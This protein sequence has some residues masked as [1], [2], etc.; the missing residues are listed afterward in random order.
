M[1]GWE[2]VTL[3]IVGNL[4]K[5]RHCDARCYDAESGECG[6][7]CGGRN[8]GA[9]LTRAQEITADMAS[10]LL[11]RCRD[12]GV[13]INPL[14]IQDHEAGTI[15]L[16]ERFAGDVGSATPYPLRRATR[17]ASRTAMPKSAISRLRYTLNEWRSEAERLFGAMEQGNWSFICPACGH[18]QSPASIKASSHGDPDRAYSDCY[19][20][21]TRKDAGLPDDSADC[22]WKSYGLFPGPVTVVCPDGSSVFAFDFAE[23]RANG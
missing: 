21:G 1:P 14:G 17:R 8:H 12:Q 2:R 4:D 3:I 13:R 10:E 11:E 15:D 20:R 16:F 5:E 6:C 18:V 19:G 9:G 23:V 22:D 7:V